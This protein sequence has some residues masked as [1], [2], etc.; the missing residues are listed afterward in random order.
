MKTTQFDAKTGGQFTTE[1]TGP[2]FQQVIS[3][4]GYFII[5]TDKGT[6]SFSKGRHDACVGDIV[7]DIIP[8]YTIEQYAADYGDRVLGIG[9]TVREFLHD[10]LRVRTV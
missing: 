1:I 7:S 5:P 8:N 9:K 10:N 2:S 4:P 3:G 6:V